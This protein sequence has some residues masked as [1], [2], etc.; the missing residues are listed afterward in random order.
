MK[1][2]PTKSVPKKRTTAKVSRMI[3]LVRPDREKFIRAVRGVVKENR[4][5]LL[6]LRRR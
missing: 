3:K 2:T 1:Q 6:E 5:I 4:D